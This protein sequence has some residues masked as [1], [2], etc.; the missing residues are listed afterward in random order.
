MMKMVKNIAKKLLLIILSSLFALAIWEA[1]L[2]LLGYRF[3]GSLFTT[4]PL[5]GWSLRPGASGWPVD[6]CAV[7][8]RINPHGHLDRER[9]PSEAPSDFPVSVLGLYL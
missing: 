6:E 2:R 8:C 9:T 7:S 3:T 1:G 4:D 5:L